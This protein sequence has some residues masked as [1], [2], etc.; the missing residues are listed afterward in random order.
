[1]ALRDKNIPE[2]DITTPEAYAVC[3]KEYRV[4]LADMYSEK[5]RLDL[6]ETL[7]RSRVKQFM[8]DFIDGSDI[9]QATR[10]AFTF[11]F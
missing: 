4:Y 10:N 1:M 7:Q 5:L 2:Y 8:Q 9:A 6:A 3:E 11:I